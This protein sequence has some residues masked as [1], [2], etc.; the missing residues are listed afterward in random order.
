LMSDWIRL[1]GSS[2]DWDGKSAAHL[3][4]SDRTRPRSGSESAGWSSMIFRHHHHR[5]PPTYTLA[6]TRAKNGGQPLKIGVSC[7]IVTVGVRPAVRKRSMSGEPSI[8]AEV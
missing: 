5:Q 6:G 7:R 8:E 4:L 3:Q 2:S 1:T